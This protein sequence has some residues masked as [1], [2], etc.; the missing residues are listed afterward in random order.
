V[1]GFAFLLWGC[2]ME[3]KLIVQFNVTDWFSFFTF[4]AE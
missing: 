3:N 2:A 1:V 4:G